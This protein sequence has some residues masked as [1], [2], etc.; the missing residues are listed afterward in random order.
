MFFFLKLGTNLDH[1]NINISINKIVTSSLT[2]NNI[3]VLYY[4]TII[5]L[6]ININNSVL[7]ELKNP[8]NL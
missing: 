6:N 2:F 5:M 3:A 4:Y 1:K 7:Y 8:N